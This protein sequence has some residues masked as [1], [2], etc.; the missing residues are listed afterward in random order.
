MRNAD[1]PWRLQF[2]NEDSACPACASSSI[3]LLDVTPIRRTP[4]RRRLA[5]IT[6]CRA[7]GL[8]FSNPLPTEEDLKQH[9]SEQGPWAADRLDRMASRSKQKSGKELP[10][11]TDGP[12]RSPGLLL[13]ALATYTAVHNPPS[14]A[15]VLDFGCGDGK[16]LNRLQDFG[17]ETSGIEPSTGVAFLRH[18][19]LTLPP[20]DGSFD[21]VVLNHVLEHVINPLGLLRRLAGSLRE[22]GVLFVSVPRLDTLPQHGDLKYCLS[23]HRHVVCFS[24]TCLRGLL[25]RA[26]FTPTAR[27]DAKE[28]DEAFT[29][30]RPV[31]LRLVAA[32]TAHPPRPPDAPLAPA[33][34]ALALHARTGGG[35]AARMRRLLPV[36]LHAALMDRDMKRQV[37]ESKRRR[38]EHADGVGTDP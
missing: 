5:F 38:S 4:Q 24:E 19:R 33:V 21:L 8:L 14:G 3:T 34:K 23:G 7:C 6:G 15:K 20:Q 29:E 16:L 2:E 36:R 11:K 31:R 26:G 17:W 10:P 25:A 28:L 22:G 37:A 1:P 18:R 35:L 32:R 30:G 27:L 9:Y 12:R 13:S